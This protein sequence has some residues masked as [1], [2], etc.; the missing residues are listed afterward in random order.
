MKKG[1]AFL[2]LGLL[3]VSCHTGNQEVKDNQITMDGNCITVGKDAPVAAKIQTTK[4]VITNSNTALSTSGMVT[5][6]PSAYAQVA[7]PFSGR[8]TNSFAPLGQQVRKG[9]PLF[10]ISSPELFEA[11]KAHSQADQQMLLAEKNLKRQ[12]ALYEGKMSS[13][14][15]WEEAQTQY[16]NAVKEHESARAALLA[17]G[18]DPDNASVGEPLTI[19]SPVSGKVVK[20]SLVIGQFL[21]DDADPPLIVAD[22]SRVWVVAH[23]KEHD[24]RF[25]SKD[26]GVSISLIAA[27]DEIITGTVVN[28]SELLDPETRSVEVIIVCDNQKGVL[29]PN[30]YG[31]VTFSTRLERV[32]VIPNKAILQDEGH[33]Y[34]FVKQA[35]RTYL[36]QEVT[37]V[38]T[39]NDSSIVASGLSEGAE[40]IVQGAFYL[41]DVK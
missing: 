23:V 31:T 20:N 6:I 7:P 28:I 16:Q 36:K 10:E 17:Y 15:E 22:L 19:V 24:L 5:A 4:V 11:A 8:I 40:I 14:R 38:E 34:V 26:S 32:L 12:Q 3:C 30:M 33:K 25:L 27:P 9:A 21:K 2:C 39:E 37:T 1:I 13:A 18:V 35:E 29:K 41:V